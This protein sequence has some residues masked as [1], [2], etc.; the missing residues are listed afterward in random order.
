MDNL[1]SRQVAIDAF[2]ALDWYHVSHGRLVHGADSDLDP[3]YKYDDVFKTLEEL[4]PTL[5]TKEIPKRVLWTGWKG[6]MPWTETPTPGISLPETTDGWN[7][8]STDMR[9]RQK[10]R[11]CSSRRP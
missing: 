10:K 6:R 1:I 7:G 9:C 2:E 3:V 5:P 11:K 4:P 8:V